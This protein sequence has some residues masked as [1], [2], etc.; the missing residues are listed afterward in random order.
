MPFAGLAELL[1]PAL[2]A[3]DQI[4]AP[5]ATALAGALALRP[6]DRAGPVRD[7][8][9]D[10]EPAVRLRGGGP[11]ALLVDDAHLLDGSSAAGAAVRGA[12]AGRR[13]DRARAR[14][15][16]GRAVA[17]RRRRPA[18]ASPRRARPR[19]RR[20]AARRAPTCPATS[21]SGST[22]RPAATRWRCSSSRRR[23][24]RLAA[25]PSA[26]PVPISTSIAAAFL[27]R[28]ER[29]PEP[30]RRALVLA[31][32]SDG[33]DLVVLARAATALGLDVGALAAGRGGRPRRARRAARSSS[34][35]RSP[36]RPSTPTR[37]RSERRAA[38][39]ALAAA[40]PDRDVD[41]RAWH[42]AAA[43]IGPDEQAS[44]ALEQAGERARER[45]A[46]ARRRGRVRARRRPCARGRRRAAACCSRPP[47]RRGWA[48]DLDRA[49]GLL[50]AGAA[51]RDPTPCSRPGSTICAGLVAMR[52]GPVMDG[53]PLVVA[54]AEHDRRG[55]SRAGGRDA[56]RG[57]ARLLL[58]R[59]HPGDAR[60]PPRARSRWP[61][62]RGSRRATFFAA[63]AQGIA[64]VA[65]GQ[66]EAGAAAVAR[67][68]RDPRGVRRAARR[69]APARLGRRSARCGCARPASGRGLIDRA[70]EQARERGARSACCRCSCTTSRATRRRP[71]S[72]R[73]PRRATTRRSGWRARPASGRSSPPRSPDSPG[74]RR[75]RGARTP[76][77]R[78]PTEAATLCGELGIGLYEVWT[79]QALGDLELGLGRPAEALA[80]HEAQAAA[81]RSR[82]IADVDL[83]P[84]PEL[85]DAYLR[86]GR[87]EDAAAAATRVRGR[88]P[89]PRGSRGRSRAR[90]AAAGC[91]PSPASSRPSSR[92]RSQLHARTPDVLRDGAHAA[93]VRGAAAPRAEARA[94]AR[95]AAGGARAVRAARRAAV[96]RSGAG[97]A[98]GDRGDRAAA[99]RRARSTS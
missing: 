99:R 5:Q 43:S 79:I 57:G 60:R 55:R 40:L 69:P 6:G 33:G 47:T 9:G 62:W 37:Q 1:R 84:A 82:G 22:G 66:G 39:A 70:F 77:A 75:G 98:G 72:G 38:H 83:S 54:A 24:A 15:A 14:R 8:R 35:I 87:G 59:R 34:G 88:A 19:G 96:G 21:S 3:L 27:R 28:F 46:Y 44:A 45:S 65:D 26:G 48:G 51:A 95:A 41:R 16:R 30:T 58:R 93:G 67:R 53:Y 12:A 56:R 11:L 29:L 97:G 2:G 4:P 80:H 90:R 23:R 52:R 25:L 42:L 32:A 50:D 78:T 7:R 17:A 85:V 10:A 18:R 81:L 61:P 20:G 49:V 74:S 91:S 94:R 31:A 86:L 68:R 89:R 71:T 63:M 13:P 92:R 73:P 36:A 76:A 64:L